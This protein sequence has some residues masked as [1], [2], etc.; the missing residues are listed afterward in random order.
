MFDYALWL[1]I[2][3]VGSCRRAFYRKTTKLLPEE[4]EREREKEGDFVVSGENN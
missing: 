1:Y 4:K 2:G 3:D